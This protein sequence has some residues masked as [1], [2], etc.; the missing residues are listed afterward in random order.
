MSNRNGLLKKGRPSCQI[1]SSSSKT[2]RSDVKSEQALSDVD[3]N[4]AS[5]I[6]PDAACKGRL[7][8]T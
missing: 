1:A 6:A 8:P 3:P 7:I 2:A 4:A 5:L